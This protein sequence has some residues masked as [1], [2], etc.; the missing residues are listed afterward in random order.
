MRQSSAALANMSTAEKAEYIGIVIAQKTAYRIYTVCRC[1]LVP[2]T[3]L[4]LVQLAPLPP[5]DSVSTNFTTSAISFNHLN[6]RMEI[7]T[8]H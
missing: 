1:Q 7:V 8:E 5:Q 6:Y 4:E 2:T 3:R